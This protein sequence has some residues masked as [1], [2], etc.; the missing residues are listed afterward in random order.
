[1]ML[2]AVGV[3]LTLWLFVIALAKP[4]LIT[5]AIIALAPTQFIFIPVSTFFLSPADLL[6]IAAGAAFA[7][8][9]ARGDRESLVALWQHR[10]ILLML[11]AY[12]VGFVVLD[13]F[14]RTL[15]RVPMAALPS[16]LAC[17]VLRKRLYLRRAAT[18]LVIAGVVDSA[19]GLVFYAMGIPIYPGRFSGMSGVNFSATAI[20]TAAAVLF[21]QHARARRWET[22]ARPGALIA[23]GAATLSQM[24]ALAFLT[25]WFVV[26]RRVMT[27]RNIVRMASV[28]AVVVGLALTVPSLRER[29]ASRNQREMGL[30]G[31]E[32]N[33]ADIRWM[34][35]RTAFRAFRESPLVGIGYSRFQEY[36]VSDPEIDQSTAGLGY[37]THNT[38]VEVLV[39][40][41]L[42]AVICF[43]LHFSQ[44]VGGIVATLRSFRRRK[45]TIVA[46]ALVGLPIVLVAAALSNVLLVYHFWAVCG[47]ALTGLTVRRREMQ[48]EDGSPAPDRALDRAGFRGAPAV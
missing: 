48:V 26:L 40:G 9:L 33:S 23:M 18:A 10:Y 25:T 20:I 21:A 35:L 19:Y 45:D 17:E 7:V 3:A 32:R 15:V 36:S 39:E 46:S 1:M 4:R 38:Y 12:V 22:L 6:V 43:G 28:A 34:V 37:G 11:A 2:V 8:R 41:G 42:F 47:I 13:T 29:L 14:S 27:P 24:G 5:Y 30:D 16:V 44:Y 31:I